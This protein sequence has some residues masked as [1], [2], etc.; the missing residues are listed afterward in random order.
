MCFRS[1][2][3]AA[4]KKTQAVSRLTKTHRE[5][6]VSARSIFDRLLPQGRKNLCLHPPHIGGTDGA[7]RAV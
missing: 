4:A 1:L 5:S 3:L 7:A 6:A 2:V